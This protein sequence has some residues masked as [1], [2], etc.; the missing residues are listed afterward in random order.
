MRDNVP[1]PFAIFTEW[2]RMSDK[3]PN[4]TTDRTARHNGAHEQSFRAAEAGVRLA[5]LLGLPKPIS[6]QRM[7]HLGRAGV[8]PRVRLG[9]MVLFAPRDLQAFVD[10]GGGT[11]SAQRD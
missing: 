3:F 7:W 8:I 6:A 9:R 5:Q 11:Y 1:G 2:E 10:A 4:Q